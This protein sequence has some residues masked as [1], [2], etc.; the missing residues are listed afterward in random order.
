M[1]ST[2]TKT[3]LSPYQRRLFGFLGVA[4][5]FEGWD[6]FA[7]T[8][9]LPN[10]RADMG[11]SVEGAGYLFGFVNLGTVLA[12]V[13]VRHADRW[14][15]KRLLTVT[16]A[17]YT[18]C[19]LGSGLAWD[20]Y[21]F[22]V[23]QF[24][25]RIFL[26]GEWAV[27]TVYAAEEFPADR[28][29]S[30]IGILQGF[31]SLGAILCAGAVP[32]LLNTE[33]GWRS[34]YLVGVL[35][36]VLLAWTRRGLRETQRFEEQQARNDPRRPLTY[37]LR[38]PY[39]RRVWQLGLIWFM[40][41]ICSNTAVSFWKDHAVTDLGFT[42]AQVAQVIT[43]AALGSMPLIFLAGKM[44]DVIGRRPGAAI[45]YLA[46]SGGVFAGYTLTSQTGLTIAMTFAVFGVT[47]VL[48]VLNSYTSELFP[49]DLRADAFAWSNNLLGRIGYVLA[50]VAI[51]MMAETTGWGAAVAPTAVFPLIALALIFW[52][53]P[54]TS[55]RELE[56]T[57]QL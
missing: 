34:V 8:Q 45:I 38:T 13:L 40:T 44:L 21:S 1:T 4:T 33:Y 7:L 57:S 48:A 3:P 52:L 39:A 36:L 18:L 15:R 27:A 6:F 2:A 53:L 31:S 25:G 22:A 9:I 23:F 35:P 30:V 43:V 10:L 24:L 47:A 56:E 19:T 12:F 54:E 26:I 32:L 49:T 17:G 37:I 28:R 42:D 50:P 29:G 5:L 51:G 41:Y 14:G 11:L 46:T 55:G 16:I 20:V